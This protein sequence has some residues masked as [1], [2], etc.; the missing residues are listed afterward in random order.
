MK[1]RRKFTDMAASP[2]TSTRRAERGVA[3]EQRHP[4][5]REQQGAPRCGERSPACRASRRRHVIMPS[6]PSSP[7]GRISSTTAI[8]TYMIA[9]LADGKEHRRDAGGD[10]DQQPAEQRAGQPAD[11]AD[12]DGD[13]A[14]HQKAGAH[15]RLEPELARRQHAAKAG[16]KDPDREI[17]R[18]QQPTLTPSADT[19]SRSRVPARMR[20]PR[21]V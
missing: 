18:A 10:A 6:S 12:D 17:E 13:E 15:G 5:G 2:S 21:R 20:M 11:A 16:E 14:R 4:V 3:A 1:P 8:N 9:S 19:V 7:R